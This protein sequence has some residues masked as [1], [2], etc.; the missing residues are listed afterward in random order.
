MPSCPTM[1]GQTALNCAVELARERHARQVRRRA[2]RLPSLEAIQT[3]PR[4][5]SCFAEAMERIGLE[6]RHEQAYAYSL[7]RGRREARGRSWASRLVL[8][9]SFT[10]GGAG[11]GIAYDID[12]LRRD[13]AT[14]GL[15]LSPARE[16]LVEES[17][18]GWKEYE[19]E[20]MRDKAGQRHHRV[21]HRE[22]RRR[23]ACTRA[24]PSPSRPAQ[25]LTDRRVPAHA[26]RLARHPAQRSASTRAAPTSSSPST[27]TTGRHHRHRDES[28]R[29]PLVRARL[30]GD[31]LPDR[32]SIAAKLAVGYT[33]ARDRATTSPAASRPPASSRPS[34]TS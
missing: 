6:V 12:E 29:V 11:G 10:L 19:M 30:Q 3:R 8:R 23:W 18:L 1:G 14:R 26:R 9:P 28:A 25:T 33:L 20:V 5:A 17:L 24:T 15:E 31:G 34:T 27:P 4:T 16:V 7:R 32:S 22:L 2:H 21:L 13:R